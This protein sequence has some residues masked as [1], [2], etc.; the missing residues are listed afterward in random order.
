M[1]YIIM[2]KTDAHWETGAL[3]SSDLVMRVGE[4]VG[5][6][7]RTGVLVAGEG[8]RPS[9]EGVRLSYAGGTRTLT[10]G[11]F[12]GRNELPASF[13]IL[14]VESIDH[15]VDWAGRYAEVV[16]E[17]EFDIRPVTEPWD[18]GMVEKPAD[19][20][21]RRYMALRKATSATEAEQKLTREQQR[22][23]DALIEESTRTGVHM[24]TVAMRSSARGRR[25]LRKQGRIDTIDG[26]FVESKELIG[27]YAIVDV[28]SIEDA[29][30]LTM[31]YLE[32]V[33]APE[34]DVREIE[35]VIQVEEAQQE[36]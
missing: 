30:A 2:H 32:V 3:P 34:V 5:D 33:D 4:L 14:S 12:E 27:G 10:P 36:A 15:A 17:A 22:D 23:L 24:V 19:Q 25:L 35:S 9:S 13:S 21:T 18:L 16:G 1:N 28:P 8:L 7:A 11:P 31:R 6:L 29:V 20:R 26:P